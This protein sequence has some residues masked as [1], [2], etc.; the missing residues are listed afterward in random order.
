MNTYLLY[1]RFQ[2]MRGGFSDVEY[3]REIAGVR[4]M[5]GGLEEPHWRE[6]LAAWPEEASSTAPAPAPAT[7]DAAAGEPSPALAATPDSVSPSAPRTGTD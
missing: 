3:R 4:E 5:L 7:P 1:C 6:Y 2:Q